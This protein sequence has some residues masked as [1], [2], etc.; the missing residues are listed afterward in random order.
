MTE[1]ALPAKISPAFR[2][3]RRHYEKKQDTILRDIV[4]SSR[5]FILEATDFD[6]WNGGTTGHDV[7]LFVPE[8]IID[9]IDLDDQ[10][11]LFERL[12][13][14]LNKA[15]PEIENEYIRAVY[16]QNK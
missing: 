10:E 11:K 8:E 14:D 2:R 15:T 1:Y 3:L 13:Q 7:I 6:N 9:L 4:D 5:I 16:V 12:Q